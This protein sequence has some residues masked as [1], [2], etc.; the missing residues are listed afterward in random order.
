MENKRSMTQYHGKNKKMFE[1]IIHTKERKE[2]EIGN[3]GFMW[4]MRTPHSS[5]ARPIKPKRRTEGKGVKPN[6]L[7]HT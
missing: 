6:T 7:I 2:K 1:Q 3:I 4:R 5:V